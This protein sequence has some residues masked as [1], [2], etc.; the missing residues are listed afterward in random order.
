MSKANGF[1]AI[2]RDPAASRVSI[3]V[4]GD[5][6]L[7]RIP[8]KGKAAANP[9]LSSTGKSHLYGNTGGFT[10]VGTFAEVPGSG[11]M[12]INVCLTRK[13]GAGKSA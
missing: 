9:P 6:L 12:R 3:K 13:V 4:M 8:L 2:G 7:I 10:P 1:E 11:D 5:D